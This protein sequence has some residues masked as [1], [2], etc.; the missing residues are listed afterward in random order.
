MI[1]STPITMLLAGGLL[2]APTSA[3]SP[4][5]P[6]PL[7]LTGTWTMESAY[8]ILADGK[9]VTGYGEHPQGLL[10]VDASGRYSLQIFRV[11]RP[12]FASGDKTSGSPDEY[13]QAVLGSSTHFGRVTVDQARHQLLFEIEAASFPNWEG[14]K[15][16]RD[17][18]YANDILSYAVPASASGNGTIAYSVWKRARP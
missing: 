14:R 5:D 6:A 9:R 13:R 3:V 8:E 1:M 10:T 7:S 11:D 2:L 12:K 16:V 4:P 18:T 15:Q 17:Y